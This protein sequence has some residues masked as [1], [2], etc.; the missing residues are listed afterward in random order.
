MTMIGGSGVQID[1]WLATCSIYD[2]PSKVHSYCREDGTALTRLSLTVSLNNGTIWMERG[3]HFSLSAPEIGYRVLNKQRDSPQLTLTT[4]YQTISGKGGEVCDDT[5]QGQYRPVDLDVSFALYPSCWPHRA[6]SPWLSWLRIQAQQILRDTDMSYAVASFIE[7]EGLDFF[8]RTVA[9]GRDALLSLTHVSERRQYSTG[10]LLLLDELR[11]RERNQQDHAEVFAPSVLGELESTRAVVVSLWRWFASVDCPICLETTSLHTSV[12]LP[13]K[14]NFC[15][16][17]IACYAEGIAAELHIQT[18][19]PFTCPVVSC[20]KPIHVNSH[21]LHLLSK[22]G[23]RK[24]LDWR[25]NVETPIALYLQRC[26]R[27][28]CQGREIRQCFP[29]TPHRVFCDTCNKS[30]CELC[31]KRL[32]KPPPTSPCS[33]GSSDHPLSGCDMAEVGRICHRYRKAKPEIQQQ[34]EEK[35]PWIKA[36]AAARDEDAVTLK[37]IHDSGMQQCPEC[38]TTIERTE[39]CFHMKC[40][41]CDTHFCYECGD[42]LFPPYYGTHHCWETSNLPAEDDYQ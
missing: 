27:R 16:E 8:E 11:L 17:C 29:G 21:I 3:P 24:V 22:T 23:H 6:K 25:K 28:C 37:W 36:Y 42:R 1:D 10:Q 7:N 9:E 41:A 32:P 26:P 34:A 33:P 13:C 35:W 14:H 2:V 31:M 15:H 12:E 39:G 20:R 19:N 40:T 4:Q 30:W 38:R 18:K 5:E